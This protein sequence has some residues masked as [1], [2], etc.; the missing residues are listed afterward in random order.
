[1]E[2]AKSDIVNSVEDRYRILFYDTDI[3][4]NHLSTHFS[5][6]EKMEFFSLLN[7]EKFGTYKFKATFPEQLM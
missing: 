7:C 6:T 3:L 2:G 4:I 5:C 1:M